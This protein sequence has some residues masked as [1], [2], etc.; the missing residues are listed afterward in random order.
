MKDLCV[1]LR[2]LVDVVHDH[3]VVVELVVPLLAA[4]PPEVV[5]ERCKDHIRLVQLGLL[6][7]LVQQG[8]GTLINILLRDYLGSRV[9]GTGRTSPRQ[10]QEVE[11]SRV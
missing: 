5:P 3:L 10:A 7:V 11:L 1:Q 9:P 6:P 2:R 8:P 4:V